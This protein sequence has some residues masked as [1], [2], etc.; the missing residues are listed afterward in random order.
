MVLE[1]ILSC[2]G[3]DQDKCWERVQSYVRFRLVH[4][5]AP[6]L[7]QDFVDTVCALPRHSGLRRSVHFV[8]TVSLRSV[9]SPKELWLLGSEELSCLLAACM[10]S[11]CSLCPASPCSP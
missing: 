6:Y 2:K 8:L 10:R 9:P 11:S 7:D 1:D 5:Y 4:S 3:Y